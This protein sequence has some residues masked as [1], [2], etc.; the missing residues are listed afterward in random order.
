[1]EATNMI[2]KEVHIST[3]KVGDTVKHDGKVMTLGKGNVK[4][5]PFMGTSIYGDSYKIGRVPVK[6]VLF[7]VQ[8]NL[9]VVYR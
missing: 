1:M 4:R 9:G 8:T 5:C 7:K 3:L 6:K 2:I